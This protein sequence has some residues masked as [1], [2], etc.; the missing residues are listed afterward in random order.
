M[1]VCGPTLPDAPFESLTCAVHFTSLP[2]SV[3][4]TLELV[5][6]GFDGGLV[7]GVGACVVGV[8]AWG[9]VAGV[10]GGAAC[11]VGAIVGTVSPRSPANGF[12]VVGV[13][14]TG[15]VVL[16]AAA[17]VAVE[18][19]AVVDDEPVDVFPVV[20]DAAGAEVVEPA[21]VTCVEPEP[22]HAASARAA[23]TTRSVVRME[24]RT[25]RGLRGFRAGWKFSAA[26]ASPPR[27][28]TPW[29]ATSCIGWVDTF[30]TVCEDPNDVRDFERR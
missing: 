18:P 20:V 14:L 2:A 3:H 24:C 15:A 27:S 19:A 5:T 22:P 8:V 9:A 11:T 29:C 26:P 23:T 12:F 16:A 13:V 21:A 30:E 28:A 10:A 4:E 7:V 25:G 1:F 6:V 17:V